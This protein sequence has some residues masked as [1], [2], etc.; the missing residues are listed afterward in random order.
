MAQTGLPP[1]DEFRKVM[2]AKLPPIIARKDI[3]RQL[4]GLVS[5]KTLANADSAGTGP[6]GA[7]QVG[8]VIVYPTEALINWL[9]ETMGV[10]RLGKNIK[11]L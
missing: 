1:E 6:L 3:G 8:R 9:I 7:Y 11:E 4:G 5:A 2:L 10:S